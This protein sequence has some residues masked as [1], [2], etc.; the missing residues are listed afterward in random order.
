MKMKKKRPEM[1]HLKKIIKLG[2]WSSIFATALL[3]T[4]RR[5]LGIAPRS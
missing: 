4:H 5:K 3:Q 2:L 1:A